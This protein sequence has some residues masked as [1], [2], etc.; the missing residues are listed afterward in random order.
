MTEGN[1]SSNFIK[2]N[3]CDFTSPDECLLTNI[4]T[5]WSSFYFSAWN[6]TN[7]L[8]RKACDLNSIPTYSMDRLTNWDGIIKNETIITVTFETS[9]RI[10]IRLINGAWHSD[11]INI[12]KIKYIFI[13]LGNRHFLPEI[14]LEYI[15]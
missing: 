10:I 8:R 13:R 4:E 11:W 3:T 14:I 9:S 7:T 1:L 5:D 6:F 2:R 15:S 12:I